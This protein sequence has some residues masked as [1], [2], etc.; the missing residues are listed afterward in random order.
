MTQNGK[1]KKQVR[2]R[3]LVDGVTYTK[4]RRRILAEREAEDQPETPPTS[5]VDGVR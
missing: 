3:M 2:A 1:F 4:A 5:P